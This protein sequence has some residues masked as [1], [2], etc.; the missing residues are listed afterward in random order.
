MLGPPLLYSV[1]AP[2]EPVPVSPEP[3][4]YERFDGIAG[5]QRVVDGRFHGVDAAAR[6]FDHQVAGVVD[7]IDVIA[8]EADQR[9][10]S[11]AADERFG[12]VRARAGQA[13]AEHIEHLDG[14]AGRQSIID[15]RGH[16]VEAGA[17]RFGHH[18]AGVADV[19]D[20]VADAARQ[21]VDAGVS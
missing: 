7:V 13:G 11:V 10:R 17:R 9:V 1:S 14:V 20:V 12:A 16:G 19:V 6:G 18:V 21:A 15:V 2:F 5:R 3:S 4:M 8:A